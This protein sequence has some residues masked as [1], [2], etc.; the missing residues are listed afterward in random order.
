MWK[1]A[2]CAAKVSVE[3]RRDRSTEHRHYISEDNNGIQSTEARCNSQVPTG[4]VCFSVLYCAEVEGFVD[5]TTASMEERHKEL[6]GIAGR[7]LKYSK[8]SVRS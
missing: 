5:D 1:C 8:E 4:A 2:H 7:V 3:T 6:A